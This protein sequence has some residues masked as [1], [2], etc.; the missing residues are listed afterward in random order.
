SAYT[1]KFATEL[2][3]SQGAPPRM[4]IEFTRQPSSVP[5]GR[6]R[7][8]TM[9]GAVRKAAA[10]LPQIRRAQFITIC[11]ASTLA[12]ALSISS[13]LRSQS[14][15]RDEPQR[16]LLVHMCTHFDLLQTPRN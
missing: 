10:P 14:P 16:D 2:S 6:R 15:A 8:I 1:E 5:S 3:C 4:K 13:P 12:E 9:A 11:S 7:Y